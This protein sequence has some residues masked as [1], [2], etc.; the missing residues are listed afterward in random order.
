MLLSDIHFLVLFLF[1]GGL[2][3]E[4]STFCALVAEASQPTV[5]LSAQQFYSQHLLSSV[6]PLISD[7]EEERFHFCSITQPLIMVEILSSVSYQLSTV[8]ML[9]AHIFTRQLKLKLIVQIQRHLFQI[10][11][12]D[13]IIFNIVMR[14]V[15]VT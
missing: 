10:E 1:V 12:E 9:L 2:K 6:V 13:M 3:M 11:K 8:S 4:S 15:E 7:F 14:E 5:F